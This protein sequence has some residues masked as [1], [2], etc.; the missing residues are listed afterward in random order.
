MAFHIYK[1]KISIL[2]T[3]FIAHNTTLKNSDS[4]L[5]SGFRM[6]HKLWLLQFAVN[7]DL[8]F[9]VNNNKTGHASGLNTKEIRLE[10]MR[11]WLYCGFSHFLA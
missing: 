11:W 6:I 8:P 9:V 3:K 4:Y 7:N 10:E 1:S 2:S 5:S